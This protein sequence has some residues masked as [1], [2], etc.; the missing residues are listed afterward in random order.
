[1][2]RSQ[3]AQCADEPPR[4]VVE[5][6]AA[7]HARLS[8][9]A[10]SADDYAAFER[11]RAADP[12]HA[13]AWQRLEALCG[14]VDTAAV[15]G[16]RRAVEHAWGEEAQALARAVRGAGLAVVLLA[17]VVPLA[18]LAGGLPAPGH[19]LADHHT[20]VGER[21]VVALADGSRVILNTHTAIDV[22][23]NGDQRRIEL[24]AGEIDVSVA[25]DASRPFTV[26]TAEGRVQALGTRFVVHR[27][28]GPETA[29]MRVT[30]RE[31]RIEL[32]PL[33]APQSACRELGPDQRARTDG[34]TVTGPVAVDAQRAAAWTRGR[35]VLDDRPA[36]EV[37]NVLDRHRPGRITF[38]ARALAGIRVSGV[39]PLD[40]TDRALL[41]LTASHPV[42]VRHYTPWL[43]VVSRAE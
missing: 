32:C 4:A 31:S 25:P 6:A 16:A 42:T 22:T 10:A 13:L 11:W 1:V 5:R 14:R 36:S 37:L 23:I 8:D 35:L 33:D 2:S 34:R 15:P 17:V 26:I 30:V 39:L 29:V 7:W 43:V 12:T 40:D 24:R 9:E 21:R 41:A 19:W 20:A 18:W 3:A 28:T 27:D 38:D